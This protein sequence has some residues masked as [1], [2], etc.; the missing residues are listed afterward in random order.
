MH[1]ETVYTINRMYT[2]SEF[3]YTEKIS[4]FNV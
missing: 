2:E 4:V 1:Y 3:L